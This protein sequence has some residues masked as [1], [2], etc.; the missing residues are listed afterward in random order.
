MSDQCSKTG[1]VLPPAP[2]EAFDGGHCVKAVGYDIRQMCGNAQGGVLCKNS[3][4][5]G[6]GLAGYFWLP[7]SFWSGGAGAL[8][9]DCWSI[10]RAVV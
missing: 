5:T 10:R 1:I 8:V 9:S 6:W 7:M 4:G 3:W 2:G